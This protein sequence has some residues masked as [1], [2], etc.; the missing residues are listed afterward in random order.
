MKQASTEQPFH[1]SSRVLTTTIL[2]FSLIIYQF[3]SSFIVG[4]LLTEPPKT[5]KTMEH[6]YKSKLDVA[7]DDIPYIQDVFKYVG[8]EWTTKLYH[9]VMTQ[10]KP[11]VPLY[12]GLNMV[13]RGLI[14]FNTDGNYAYKI[15]KSVCQ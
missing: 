8:E 12:T 3:Y 14:A 15:L 4:A 7:I 5:I 2:I 11:T 13:K 9:R 10:Q 6:L 1:L